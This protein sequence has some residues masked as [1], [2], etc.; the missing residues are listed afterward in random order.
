MNELNLADNHLS[1]SSSKFIAEITLNKSIKA[2]YI[3]GNHLQDD[4]Y[5]QILAQ[6]DTLEVLDISENEIQTEGAIRIFRALK[7]R[8]S[9][10]KKL[11]L[12]NN[13]ITKCAADEIGVALTT[14]NT[15]E[16]LNLSITQQIAKHRNSRN[17]VQTK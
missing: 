6:S 12:T 8:C 7:S 13:G 10:L 11:I 17:H 4:E 15:L 2:L 3:Q 16:V 1:T 14:N 5:L 9:Y